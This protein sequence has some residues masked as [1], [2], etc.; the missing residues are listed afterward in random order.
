MI[1]LT[2]SEDTE[3]KTIEK[4]TFIVLAVSMVFISGANARTINSASCSQSNVQA[5]ITAAADGDIVLIPTGSCIWTTG[6]T[7]VNKNI[8]VIGAGIGNT[9]ISGN[10][11]KF[12]ITPTTKA[13]FRVS[14][15]TLS[16]DTASSVFLI[17]GNVA[18][19]YTKG[20]RIDHIR[21]KYTGNASVVN[22]FQINGVTWGVIDNC[23]FDGAGYGIINQAGYIESDDRSSPRTIGHYAH[24]LPLN[25]GTDEAVYFED[26]TVNF[27]GANSVSYLFNQT[28]GGNIVVRYNSIK[29]TYFQNHSAK[30]AGRGG[31]KFEIY[32]NTFVGDGFIW[33]AMLR[34]GT[35]V[36]F[37][38]T[39]SGYTLTSLIIDNQRTCSTY[40]A[41]LTRCDG[42]NIYDGNTAGEYGWPCI[43]QIGRGQG[44]L[45][46]QPSVPLYSW[47]NGTTITCAT[48]GAC[49]NTSVLTLNTNYDLC[50][51]N[52]PPTLSTHLKTT[53]DASPH[54]GGVLD[55]VNNG[56]TQKPG[57]V[58]YTYPHPL[59]KPAPALNLRIRN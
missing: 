23:M 34:A 5:A 39:I 50:L 3:M 13:S 49:N 31:V 57:Y 14:G 56:S 24:S 51:S 33:P 26:N 37:N 52:P 1:N 19:A 40:S 43:D 15:M 27:S 30:D 38:N 29:G 10:G 6:I 54:A 18:T 41:I 44:P 32:N 25:L 48:G 12:S 55:Y 53:G 11:T 46:S 21:F 4:V 42:R 7:W 35:G 36:I 47:N 8:S 20:W 28:Y 16:G 22:A 17:L 9:V 45:G 2:E 59:T 58:P